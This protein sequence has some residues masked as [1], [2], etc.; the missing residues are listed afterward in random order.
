MRSLR[1]PARPA[2]S[3][4]LSDSIEIAQANQAI[5]SKSLSN[6]IDKIL[7]IPVTHP[8][9]APA[10]DVASIASTSRTL[11]TT[12]TS[13]TSTNIPRVLLP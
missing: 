3:H 10:S 2:L 5:Q 8:R 6:Q 9:R 7:E 12:F 1:I 4:Q 13:S 11:N